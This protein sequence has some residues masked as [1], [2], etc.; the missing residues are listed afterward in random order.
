MMVWIVENLKKRFELLRRRWEIWMPICNEG[1][2]YLFC[3]VEFV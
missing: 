3:E 1:L 2:V